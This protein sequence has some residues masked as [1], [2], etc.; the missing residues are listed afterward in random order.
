MDKPPTVQTAQGAISGTSE[1]G[2]CSFLGVPY[3][4]STGGENRWRAPVPV[5]PWTGLR[6]SSKFGPIAPQIVGASFTLRETRH[7]ED[8]LNLNVWTPSLNRNTRMPVMVWIHGGGNLGGA[9]SEDAFD[10]ARLAATGVVVVTFNYRLGAFG[11]LAHPLFGANFAVLDQVAALT[12]VRDNIEGMGG[13]PEN[14]TIF[15]ESAGAVAVRTLLSTPSARGL[16]QRAIIQSAGFERFAFAPGWSIQRATEAADKM[17]DALGT[18]DPRA[19][20]AIPTDELL[21]A[22]HQHSGIF[23]PPGQVHTPANLVWMPVPDDKVVAL[24]GFP[25]WSDNVPVMFGCLEN[26][27]RYFIKPGGDYS[28]ETVSRMARA[29][30]GPGADKALHYLTEEYDDPYAMLDRLYSTAI[31]FEPA[32]ETAK[33]FAADGRRFYVYHFAR[34]SPGAKASGDLVRHSAEIRYVFGNLDIDGY[35]AADSHVSDLMQEAWTSFARDGIPTTK[36]IGEW[37]AYETENPKLTWIEEDV[38]IVPHRADPLVQIFNSVRH[39]A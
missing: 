28:F 27:A 22:S 19:L 29:L 24:E 18:R 17:F 32:F 12:W 2:I 36:P 15:G 11:Y 1:S 14:V 10:G 23:P 16:F 37:P 26:E 25:G 6:D 38:G 31:W 39:L 8:C 5:E 33:R 7:S 3:A 30:V 35:E 21:G 13:N 9:G 20:R 34:C 4:E